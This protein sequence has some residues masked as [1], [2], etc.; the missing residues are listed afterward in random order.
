MAVTNASLASH[1]Q[2]HVQPFHLENQKGSGDTGVIAPITFPCKLESVHIS[3]FSISDSPFLSLNIARWLGPHGFTSILFNS[4]FIIYEFGS[5]GCLPG[6]V[7]L[8]STP[9]YLQPSDLLCF[10]VGGGAQGKY[11]NLFGCVALRPV[12]DKIV[13]FNNLS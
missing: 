1:L 9:I 7:A 5:S 13:Y 10:T 12:Q 6:G 4:T 11:A 2:L 8:G 3:T